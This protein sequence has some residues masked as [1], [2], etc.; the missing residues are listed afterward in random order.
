MTDFVNGTPCKHGHEGLRYAKNNRCV[1][2]CRLKNQ[3][4]DRSKNR[5]RVN[6]WRRSR[7][8]YNRMAAARWRASNPEKNI[9]AIARQRARKENLPFNITVDDISIPEFCPVF[10]TTMTTP[11]LDQINAGQGYVKGNVCVISM[12]ANRLKS[13]ATIEQLEQIITYMKKKGAT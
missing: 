5:D 10:G 8:E 7:P 4:Q 13:D 11:S 2:C 1:E 3:S 9:V 6:E 12:E